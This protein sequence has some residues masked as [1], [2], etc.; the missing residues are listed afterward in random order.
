MG[1][2]SAHQ[3]MCLILYAHFVGVWVGC[4]QACASGQDD[5]HFRMTSA[6]FWANHSRN[7]DDEENLSPPWA[8][9]WS[10][11]L[12]SPGETTFLTISDTYLSFFVY[13]VNILLYLV[14]I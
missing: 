5:G 9:L 14:N 1:V 7:S 4:V 13:S 2:N 3:Q 11:V 6:Y 12:F 8:M 10:V